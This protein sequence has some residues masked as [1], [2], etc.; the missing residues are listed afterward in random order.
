MSI[1]PTIFSRPRLSY[2]V[3]GGARLER[4]RRKPFRLTLLLLN[5]GGRFHRAELYRELQEIG[6]GEVICLEGPTVAYDIEPLSRQFPQFRFLLLQEDASSGE[7]INCG[8]EEA[9][10]KWVLVAWSDMRISGLSQELKNLDRLD[11]AGNLCTVP[12]L[13]NQRG[14]TLPSLQ[15]PA[16]IH[17]RLKLLPWEPLREGMKTI[18]PFDYCGIYDRERFLKLGGFDPAIPNPYWQ[19]LDFGFRA[20][21]WGEKI[22][23]DPTIQFR[24]LEEQGSEDSTPDASYKLFFLKNMALR[25]KGERVKLPLAKLLVYLLRSD[26]GPIC[27]YKEYREVLR[28]VEENGLRFKND[29]PGLI[30]G[31]E[32]PE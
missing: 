4:G 25:R 3:V 14:E 8:I 12:L 28:W 27:A 17:S 20:F 7:R 26:T 16:L 1:I 23:C 22:Q 5:R 31:W 18:L 32:V 24:Y 15:I 11:F 6:L 29:A 10:S 9:R 19:K 2:T 21:L 30:R 13:K